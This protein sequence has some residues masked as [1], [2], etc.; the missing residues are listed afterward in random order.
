MKTFALRSRLNSSMIEI[1]EGRCAESSE[2]PVSV[3]QEF[4]KRAECQGRSA[5]SL[6]QGMELLLQY[7]FGR[8]SS[9]RTNVE[10][11][12]VSSSRE[13]ARGEHDIHCRWLC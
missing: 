12:F 11:R 4:G 3:K 2:L 13:A 7:G 6:L 5:E 10:N 8:D 1:V 9:V